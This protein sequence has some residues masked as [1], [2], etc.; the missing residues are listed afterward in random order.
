M[1]DEKLG[2]SPKTQ[3]LIEKL[4]KLAERK[5]YTLKKKEA[6]ETILKTYDLFDL[7]RPKNVVWFDHLT[8]EFLGN[9]YSAPSATSA[10]RASSAKAYRAYSAPSAPSAYRAY[11]ASSAKAYSAYRASSAP[12]AYRASSAYGAYGASIDTDFDY[13]VCNFEYMENP[14]GEITENDRKYFKYSQLVIKAKE[15][16]VGYFCDW[17]DVLY[18]VPVPI[19][20]CDEQGRYHNID[21]P[22]IS[23]PGEKLY[24]LH[25]V[26]FEKEWWEKIKDDTLTPEE[27]FAID[28]LEHR[29]IAYEFMD[30]AKMKRLKD[31]AILDEVKDD[32]RGYPMKIISFKVKEVEEPLKYYNCHCPTTGREYYI[33][34]NE[35]TC[36]K[37]KARSFGFG[38]VVFTNEW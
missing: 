9:A 3:K 29:R 7:P 14:D 19:I 1:I 18:L 13:S 6:E 16:G 30:K 36:L 25:G 35:E 8:Q 20:Y 17:K 38:D 2:Y 4:Y 15:F 11:S 24:F 31:F 12:S 28:N 5:S 23:W 21:G 22:A 27:V 34:T 37:A 26:Q 32:G 10:Y 33:G